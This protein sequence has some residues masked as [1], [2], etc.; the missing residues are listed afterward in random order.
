MIEWSGIKIYLL[1]TLEKFGFGK[2]LISWVKLLYSSPR[3]SVRTNN[4]QSEYFRL[5]RSTRQGCPLSPLLFAITVEPLS[6]A[7][8]SN[9]HITGILRSG[10]E[11]RVSLYA[12]DLLLYVSNLPVSVPAAL[13]TLK[14][15]GQISGYKLN[16]NK[17]EIFPINT[18]AKNDLLHNFPLVAQHSFTYLP[19]LHMCLRIFTRLPC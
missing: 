13:T 17:S 19:T 1:Y 14:S 5:Y 12:D 4:L 3:A 15:F 6:I 16:L 11:L 8:P 18:T 7:L 10:I 9:P 2:N